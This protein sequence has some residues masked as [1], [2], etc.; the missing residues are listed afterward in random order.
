MA[1]YPRLFSEWQIRSTTIANRVVFAPTCPTWV[2][3]PYE[4][5]FTDQAVA[6]YEERAKAGCGLIIIGGT[7]IH[8]RR[9]T[10]EFNFPGL[11]KRRAG[12]GARGASSTRCTRTARSS[13]ASSCTPACARCR[14]SRRTPRTTST[15]EW[16]LVAPSQVP[17]GEYPNAPMPKELEEHE[18]EE[19]LAGLRVRAPAR[20]SR[21]ASTASSSTCR[22]ATCRGSSCRRSTTTAPTA[23][24]ARREP[25]ALPGRGAAAHA[26]RRSATTPSSATASTRPRSGRAT[27]RWTTSS[28]SSPT[29]S[30]RRTSTTSTSPP[31]STTRTS[32]RR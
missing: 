9:S 8:Q 3:D 20:A 19:I 27:W 16:Y 22:T 32:T 26:R 4:G 14:C 25:A 31:A 10:P 17:P 6:Y 5:V 13:R 2:A 21:P 28:G 7:I 30:A 15:R 23:G 24:A 29:S 1:A 12:R 18:I 11:W